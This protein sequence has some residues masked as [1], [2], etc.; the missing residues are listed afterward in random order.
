M[1]DTNIFIYIYLFIYLLYI[2]STI[3][4]MAL[5]TGPVAIINVLF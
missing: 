2:D 5:H 1:S 3:I 4:G